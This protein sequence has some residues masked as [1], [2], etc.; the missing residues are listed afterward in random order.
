[1]VKH[2]NNHI[3]LFQ[4]FFSFILVISVKTETKMTGQD[5]GGFLV[6]IHLHNVLQEVESP[7]LMPSVTYDSYESYKNIG[8]LL[9]NVEDLCPKYIFLHQ[10]HHMDSRGKNIKSQIF[11]THIYIYICLHK[12]AQKWFQVR[13]R[14]WMWRMG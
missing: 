1:M 14:R 4:S 11:Y 6:I 10:Q 12:Y 13:C 7:Y 2:K 3:S 8:L 9:L 5:Y